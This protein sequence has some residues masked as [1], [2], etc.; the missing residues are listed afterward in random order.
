MGLFWGKKTQTKNETYINM[1]II[2]IL[3]IAVNKIGPRYP[4]EISIYI[5]NDYFKIEFEEFEEIYSNTFKAVITNSSVSAALD[6]NF[7]LNYY[8]LSEKEAELLR[9]MGHIQNGSWNIMIPKRVSQDTILKVQSV[10]ENHCD[11]VDVVTYKISK[12]VMS[13]RCKPI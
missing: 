1:E 13:V 10:I 7:A 6:Y 3:N 2:K 12:A 11:Q 5:S 4:G 8:Q 9:H